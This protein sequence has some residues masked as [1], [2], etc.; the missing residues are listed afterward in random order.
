VV[1]YAA[2]SVMS[3]LGQKRTFALQNVMS[4]LPPMATLIAYFGMP[5]LGYRQT[6]HS[7]KT[8]LT[9]YRHYVSRP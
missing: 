5:A 3:A 4:A 8:S 7:Q 9:L 2:E 6:S 1:R